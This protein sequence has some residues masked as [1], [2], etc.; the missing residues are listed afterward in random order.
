MRI[1]LWSPLYNPS[2]GGAE[3]YVERLAIGLLRLGCTVELISNSFE[4]APVVETIH[5][6]RIT[7]LPFP[8]SRQANIAAIRS[9]RDGI[10]Q[11]MDR[12]Q[13]ELVNLHT[14]GPSIA[15]YELHRRALPLPL[16]T[17][18]HGIYPNS[19]EMQSLL[20][21]H[22]GH[23]AATAATSA[24]AKDSLVEIVGEPAIDM[25]VLLPS[26]DDERIPP[27]P[28]PR[29][30]A[31]VLGVGRL[32]VDKGWDT[33]LDALPIVRT[34]IPEARLVLIG[35]GPQR[36]HLEAGIAERGLESCVRM[37]GIVGD[38][39]LVALI[40]ECN[41]VC[42]PSLDEGFGMVAIE[43]STRARPVVA[44][45]VGGLVEAVADGVTGLLV[46]SADP[47]ALAD[48]LV[49]VLRDRVLADEMGRCGREIASAMT[50]DGLAAATRDTYRRALVRRQ[51]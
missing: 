34:E 5:D 28:A 37:T 1:L 2:I 29:E 39:E 3:R 11:V 20:T 26:I 19:A 44:S 38:D 48:A 8:A 16:V 22:F 49:T 4:D 42:V 15:H 21:A 31:V 50:V 23:C 47:S 7:R 24:A 41:V 13:P 40:D 45:S 30:G 46:P 43:A 27:V 17:T 18:F 12:L 6:I 14:S 35:D 10:A 51:S 25:D 33:L 32:T 9:V 36:A